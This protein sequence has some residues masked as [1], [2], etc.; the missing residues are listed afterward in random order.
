MEYGI[1]RI[2]PENYYRFAAMVAWRQTGVRQQA[3]NAPACEDVLRELSNPNLTVYALET[4]G[5]LVG[6]ISLV[7]IPKVSKF[8]H[9]H[10]YV[11]EL[12][13]EPGYRRRGYA[14]ALMRKADEL[15]IKTCATG[16]RLYVNVE[17]PAAKALYEKCGYTTDGTADFMEKAV[18][19]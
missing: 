9:G 6:W 12:W 10:V 5:V 2:T 13:V 17:N 11:D 15:A 19:Q 16:V 3:V 18:R 14:Q 7:Y 1:I 8:R 4:E